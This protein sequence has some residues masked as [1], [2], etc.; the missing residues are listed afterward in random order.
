MALVLIVVFTAMFLIAGAYQ[1][2]HFQ[3]FVKGFSMYPEPIAK[4][5]S[6]FAKDSLWRMIGQVAVISYSLW[7]VFVILMIVTDV[8]LWVTDVPLAKLLRVHPDVIEADKGTEVEMGRRL[9]TVRNLFLFLSLG[10]VLIV[11][12]RDYLFSS[13][14]FLMA[15]A[16]VFSLP[17]TI[18]LWRKHLA[19][20]SIQGL[21]RGELTKYQNYSLLQIL[22]A[23][24]IVAACFLCMAVLANLL[25][26]YSSEVFWGDFYL[27]WKEPAERLYLQHAEFFSVTQ[28]GFLENLLSFSK[29]IKG[30]ASAVLAFLIPQE[31]LRFT[32]LLGLIFLATMGLTFVSLFVG[33]LHGIRKTIGSVFL[34]ILVGVLFLVFGL[35]TPFP[36]ESTIIVSIAMVAVSYLTTLFITNLLR[37]KLSVL[38]PNP[39]CQAPNEIDHEYCAFCG[40]R[41]SEGKIQKGRRPS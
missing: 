20:M 11:L 2:F 29:E 18:L 27:R 40:V 6:D 5:M 12:L 17:M 31:P 22:L 4:F 13:V 28:P 23:G 26:R 8:V 3:N 34:P 19:I 15:F 1:Y 32:V 24:F 38:C 7:F 35:V 10:A 41:L 36:P 30:A 33:Y 9:V 25:A 21:K 14:Y 37:K 39:S 16:L